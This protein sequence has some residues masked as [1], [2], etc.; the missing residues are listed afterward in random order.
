MLLKQARVQLRTAEAQL[1]LMTLGPRQEAVDEAKTK[2]AMADQ[3]VASSQATLDLHTLCAPIAGTVESLNC[4]PGQTL[5]IGT[6]VGEVI[7]IRELFV[8]VYFPARTTRLLHP[9]M[10]ARVD[11]SDGGH[12]ESESAAKD[13]L[14]GKLTFIGSAADPQTGNYPVRI[15]IDNKGTRLRLGQVV[16][17][18]VLL[19]TEESLIAVPDAAIFDQGEGPVLAVVRDKK[20]KLLHPEL[21]AIEDGNVAVSKTDLK[22]GEP[23]VVEGAYAVKD[24]TEATIL[25]DPP[26]AHQDAADSKDK[27]QPIR[28][29]PSI[30]KSRSRGA[31]TSDRPSLGIGPA[32][33]ARSAV[34]R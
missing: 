29:S 14:G 27:S 5:T 1:K 9:G 12:P 11:L 28:K 18:T 6:A 20:I 21:G 4:H 13:V 25:P 30:R 15:L 8:T 3:A 16:K 10:L 34:P 26:T 24:G 31:S 32:A 2:I 22:E 7:D 33:S 19:K 17:T 23:V